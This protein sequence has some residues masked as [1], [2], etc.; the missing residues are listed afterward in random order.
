M[1]FLGG[2]EMV[3]AAIVVVKICK[4]I[5]TLCST[6][7]DV[8]CSVLVAD[9]AEHALLLVFAAKYHS[10]QLLVICLVS[11]A[12]IAALTAKKCFKKEKID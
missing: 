11:V 4:Y 5:P 3:G 10:V 7:E 9:A 12:N 6:T 1:F 8:P 2:L